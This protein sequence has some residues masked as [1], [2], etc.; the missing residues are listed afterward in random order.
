MVEPG[1]R[2]GGDRT[3]FQAGFSGACV[4]EMMLLA[5]RGNRQFVLEEQR[6]PVGVPKPVVGVHENAER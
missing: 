4:A 1:V 2:M 5:K 3:G 6:R